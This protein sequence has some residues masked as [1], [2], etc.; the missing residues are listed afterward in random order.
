MV[1]LKGAENLTRLLQL[2][3]QQQEMTDKLTASTQEYVTV[4][5]QATQT[6]QRQ[7]IASGETAEQIIAIQKQI[8][9]TENTWNSFGKTSEKV[10]AQ[11]QAEID[12]LK[13]KL[14]ALGGSAT[15]SMNQIN[16][17][18]KNTSN[19]F[20]V[21]GVNVESVL[22]RMT[23][24]MI[25]MQLLFVPI[26][27]GVTAV[28]EWFTKLSAEEEIAKESLDDYVDSVKNL[29]K[30]LNDLPANQLSKIQQ[31]AF[32]IERLTDYINGVK[33]VKTHLEGMY[34]AY[35]QIQSIAPGILDE[36]RNK[37]D[38]SKNIGSARM[39]KQLADA[40]DYSKLQDEINSKEKILNETIETRNKT[41]LQIQENQ[42]EKK[43]LLN[44][45]PDIEGAGGNVFTL[46]SQKTAYAL[47][48]KANKE[49]YDELE[50]NFKAY[51]RSIIQQQSA[52]G[53][54]ENELLDKYGKTK[55]K[56]GKKPTT[57]GLNEEIAEEDALHKLS[58]ANN[59]AYYDKSNKSFDDEKQ[60]NQRNEIENLNHASKMIDIITRWH[61]KVNE[62]DDKY[63]ARLLNV[64][65][66][67]LKGTNDFAENL[68]AITD[69]IKKSREEDTKT[70]NEYIEQLLEQKNKIDQILRER[71][72]AQQA[73]GEHHDYAR[74]A[75][76]F[77]EA[78]GGDNDFKEQ[79]DEYDR[80]IEL[81]KKK[82][83]DFEEQ[84]TLAT[85]NNNPEGIEKNALNA[86]KVQEDIDALTQQKQAALDQKIIDGKKEVSDK[87]IELAQQTFNA[88]KTINDN[89]IAQEQLNLEIR[90]RSI[91]LKYQEEVDAVNASAG[92][93]I[94]KENELAKLAAQ[95]AA[96]QNALQ[97]Q[98]NQLALKKAISDKQAAEAG[99]IANTALAITKA[100]PLLAVPATAAIGAADI[101][102]IAAIG[103][104]QYAAAAST[105][106]PQFEHG[107][108]TATR[109]FIAG[110]AGPERMTTPSG[111]TMLAEKPG[112]YSAPIGTKI[113]TAA[114]TAA[115]MR[116][117][118]SSIGL[119]VDSNGQLKE[120]SSEMTD[121]RIVEKL[122][123]LNDTMRQTAVMQRTI[124]NHITISG[125][126]DLQLY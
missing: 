28:Y 95:N 16:V 106:L 60:L 58:L 116:F 13:A 90:S 64:Q 83:K 44:N 31:D 19:S 112:I 54:K 123:D 9:S 10:N 93:Q 65:A 79:Q 114:E 32:K 110:E 126:N 22:A 62:D 115:L 92:Y 29:S 84:Q 91:Q 87:T 98:Q 72:A 33:D 99:I 108:T 103:A 69:K 104:V 38:F 78:F 97:Q 96:S 12:A 18:V 121:K 6:I 119:R 117:A 124:K 49:N 42:K 76:P 94:T 111:Q 25:A 47:K 2:T 17:A 125:R 14:A 1:D 27:A 109:Y 113:D 118:S 40:K 59:Q 24:R 57:K 48:L 46:A 102:L 77:L 88:I 34:A 107:G 7:G 23:V 105:P 15:N 36:Y 75:A 100:L 120:G 68:K 30:E 8:K 55:D 5:N 3:Q 70:A 51:S 63:N 11:F 53:E 26:I 82:K 39:N 122:D 4:S 81:A 71:I 89:Q 73:A 67:Q 66:E 74:S 85:A 41:T 37:E 50:K 52:L 86:A 45:P 56:A 35:K 43:D 61:G 20:T 80:Q 101:A 21:M